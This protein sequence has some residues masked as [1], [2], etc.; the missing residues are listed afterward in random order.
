M[1][2]QNWNSVVIAD[3]FHETLCEI[4]YEETT[5]HYIFFFKEY[6]LKQ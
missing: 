3:S 6:F 5:A 1:F 4:I 2:C